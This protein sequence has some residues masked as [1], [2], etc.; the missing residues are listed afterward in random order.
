M[1]ISVEPAETPV[2]DSME[3]PP[4]MPDLLGPGAS[5]VESMGEEMVYFNPMHNFLQDMDF[6]MSWDMDLDAFS[7]PQFEFQGPSPNSSNT[8]GTVTA[9]KPSPCN[10]VRDPSRGHWAFKRSPWLWEPQKGPDY[11]QQQKEALRIDEQS[12]S[13]TPA[14]ERLMERP[15]LKLEMSAHQRDRIFSIVLAQNKDPL[16]VPSFPSLDLLNYLLQAHFVQDERQ[17]DSWIHVASFDPENT[18]PEL[19]ASAI[20]SGAGFISVPAIWQFGLAMHEV[21]RLGISDLVSRWAVCV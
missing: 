9:R 18:L 16:K 6:S 14:F 13:Q 15:S 8:A 1:D 10:A 21:V 12:I 11:V 7:I 3:P 17:F 2:D 20:A 19:L 5:L 4:F